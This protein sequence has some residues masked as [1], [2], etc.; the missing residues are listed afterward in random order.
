MDSDDT[1]AIADAKATRDL[2]LAEALR[3][4]AKAIAHVEANAEEK[5]AT[6]CIADSMDA[7]G[8]DWRI[9]AFYGAGN[10][11]VRVDGR[12][13]HRQT[14]VHSH[15][16]LAAVMQNDTAQFSCNVPKAWIE[17]AAAKAEAI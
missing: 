17:L 1:T 16:E 2:V 15:E 7:G 11:F 14:V 8:L 5:I 10:S 9:E 6:V 4:A 13:V 3:L 12:P